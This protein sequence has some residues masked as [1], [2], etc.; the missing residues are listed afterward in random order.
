VEDG[1]GGREGGLYERDG[2]LRNLQAV[3][4]PRRSVQQRVG[5]VGIGLSGAAVDIAVAI[6]DGQE[7]VTQRVGSIASIVRSELAVGGT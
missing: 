7:A 2:R 4:E 1:V 3:G 5:I 6:A